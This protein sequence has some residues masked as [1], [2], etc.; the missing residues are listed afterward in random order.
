VRLLVAMLLLLPSS[1]VQATIN[2]LKALY[3]VL[4]LR[5]PRPWG[6]GGVRRISKAW[7]TAIVFTALRNGIIDLTGIQRLELLENDGRAR[8]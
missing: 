4:I 2:G 8:S 3:R 5:L 7:N 1:A 6:R